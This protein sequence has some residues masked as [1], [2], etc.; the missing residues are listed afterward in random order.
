MVYIGCHT[1]IAGGLQ[2]AAI[3]AHELGANAFA[4]FT[5]NQRQWKVPP[6]TEEQVSVFCATVEK[7]GFSSKA[8]LPHDSYLI[9][10]GS[11]IEEK[12]RIA[13]DAFTEEMHRCASLHLD[14]LNFHPG[15]HLG[16]ISVDACLHLVA[17]SLDKAME[18]VPSVRPVIE[19][20]AGQGTNVGS[21]F[22]EIRDIIGYSKHPES[23]GVCIDTCHIFAAGYDI[24][25]REAYEKTFETF[26]TIIGFSRLS[27]MHLNDAKSSFA[28]HVDRHESLGNGSIGLQ[29]FMWIMQDHRFEN[30]PLIL[31]TP[32][33]NK[34]KEEIALLFSYCHEN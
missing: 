2:N 14:K 23:I 34:W 33:E 12:R 26:E 22:Q 29:P 6:L 32:A 25:T 13:V 7:L 16:K 11:P 15:S 30:V 31:E 1:H 17:D 18:Q 4:M 27:G 10:L 19:T 5:K 28:S 20:T 9:N 8:I 24:R 21:T 3:Q